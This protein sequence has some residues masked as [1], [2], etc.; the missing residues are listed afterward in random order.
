MYYFRAKLQ[1]QLSLIENLD[2]G[3][4]I[5]FEHQKRVKRDCPIEIV[6]WHSLTDIDEK[7]HFEAEV[8]KVLSSD[9]NCQLLGMRI[10][11]LVSVIRKKQNQRI[12]DIQNVNL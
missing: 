10:R 1:Y 5:Y 12:A 6:D 2:A 4:K 7:G 8:Y 11:E 9:E 3:L